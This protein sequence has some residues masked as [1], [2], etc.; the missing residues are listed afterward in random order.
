[1]EIISK[2]LLGIQK[3]TLSFK[4]W[5]EDVASPATASPVASGTFS[6]DIATFARPIGG[7][8]RRQ[9]NKKN[10]NKN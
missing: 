2:R 10:K 5:L 9:K 7:L 4:N 8:I 1:M 3:E 6:A